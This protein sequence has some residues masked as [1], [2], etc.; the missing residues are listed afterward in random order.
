[1]EPVLETKCMT[2]VT[3]SWNTGFNEPSFRAR[4]SQFK[5]LERDGFVLIAI[6][7]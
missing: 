5:R 2:V 6:A 1:M 7:L 4:G 3:S